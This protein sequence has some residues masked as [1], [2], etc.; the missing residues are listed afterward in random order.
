MKRLRIIKTDRTA[1]FDDDDFDDDNYNLINKSNQDTDLGSNTCVFMVL[2]LIFHLFQICLQCKVSYTERL[3]LKT[4][5]F[6]R[7]FYFRKCIEFGASEFSTTTER[8]HRHFS[9]SRCN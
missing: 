1:L 9:H 3:V 4:V 7:V 6:V 2:Y 8:Y 5:R